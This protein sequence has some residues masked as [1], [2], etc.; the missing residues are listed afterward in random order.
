MPSPDRPSGGPSWPA[1]AADTV[2]TIVTT[3]ADKTVGPLTL[4]ARGLVFGI[5]VGIMA[6]AALVF[7]TIGLIRLLDI[8]AFPGRIW[9]TYALVGGIFVLLGSFLWIKRRPRSRD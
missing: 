7:A 8:Y 1:Q 6:Q 4:V 2:E 5:V 9:A 3:V